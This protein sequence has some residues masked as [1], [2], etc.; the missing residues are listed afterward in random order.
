[1]VVRIF[2]HILVVVYGV[3]VELMELVPVGLN[4]GRFIQTEQTFRFRSLGKIYKQ[5]ET[6]NSI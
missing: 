3:V 5:K 6:I 1:M 2:L 4:S